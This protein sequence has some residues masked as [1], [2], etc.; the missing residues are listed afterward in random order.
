MSTA[1][2]ADGHRRFGGGNRRGIS[3][4]AST[5]VDSDPKKRTEISGCPGTFQLPS[6][7]DSPTTPIR[8]TVTDRGS[9]FSDCDN[10]RQS[11]PDRRSMDSS[12]LCWKQSETNN[13]ERSVAS[14]RSEHLLSRKV[15]ISGYAFMSVAHLRSTDHWLSVGHLMTRKI[16]QRRTNTC[17]NLLSR[18]FACLSVLCRFLAVNWN[19]V[20]REM[21]V[22]TDHWVRSGHRAELHTP[23]PS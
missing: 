9:I 4:E 7:R 10:C 12:S 22:A 6:N 23:K 3:G 18:R 8:R 11:L 15:V 16:I 1:Y 14:W 17:S 13:I 20:H 21:T 5:V 19:V 2:S